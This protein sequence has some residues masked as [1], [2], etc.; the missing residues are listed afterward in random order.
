MHKGIVGNN[1]V[2]PLGSFVVGYQ[3]CNLLWLTTIGTQGKGKGWTETDKRKG[4]TS[5]TR[6]SPEGERRKTK[7]KTGRNRVR[8]IYN[9][10]L[11]VHKHDVK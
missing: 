2:T 3:M 10:V 4:K 7:E 6:T 11:M 5:K 9:I 1:F 8:N